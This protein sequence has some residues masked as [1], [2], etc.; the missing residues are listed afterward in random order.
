MGIRTPDPRLAKAM[1]YQLS[2]WPK[3]KCGKIVQG[4]VAIVNI[5]GGFVEQRLPFVVSFWHMRNLSRRE[6]LGGMLATAIA[7]SACDKRPQEAPEEEKETN[8]EAFVAIEP[9]AF[10]DQNSEYLE[11]IT[12][13]KG[14]Y[15]KT[16]RKKRRLKLKN[17]EE[18]FQDVGLKFYLV[19]KGDTISEIRERLTRYKE[20]AHLKEQPGKL[21]SFNIPQRK[22]RAEMWIPIPIEETDRH[23]TEAQFVNYASNALK[24]LED[25][26]EYGDDLRKILK[27]VSH[28]E[29]IVTLL[30]IA[31]QEGG[32]KPLGQFELHRWEARHRAFSFSYFHILMKGPGFVARKKLNLTEGQ[33]YHPQNAVKLFVGYLVEKT[34]EVHKHADRFFP[35]PEH[36][37]EFAK[38]YN[39]KSWKKK[40]PHYIQN[41]E[42]YY[43]EAM[44]HL[45]RNGSRWKKDIKE[46]NLP[47]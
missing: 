43:K 2:Y 17:G 41:V 29:F 1:L 31:K 4:F 36:M 34:A 40:N 16:Q 30:A 18:I 37:E 5:L 23:L 35:L 7:A 21:D 25:D 12:A 14:E 24:E 26:S 42:R 39:G 11:P 13:R 8:E 6:M 20:F 32:G 45:S 47:D 27:R 38:F 28:R 46:A 33:L 22:L 44:S 3:G 9:N 10:F 19:K 15:T